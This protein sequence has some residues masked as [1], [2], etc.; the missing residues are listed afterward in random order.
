MAEEFKVTADPTPDPT[1]EEAA[2]LRLQLERDRAMWEGAGV[3]ETVE[4]IDARLAEV[5]E[6]EVA[7]QT[8]VAEEVVEV[9]AEADT[10]SGNYEDRTVAQLTALAK[11]RGVEGYST[12]NKDELVNVLREG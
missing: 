7:E 2:R 12:M 4:A 10:G 6:A 5:P 3:A 9:E 11:Q 8:E 1:P